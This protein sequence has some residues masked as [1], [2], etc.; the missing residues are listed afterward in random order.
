M[1][2]LWGRHFQPCRRTTKLQMA[3]QGKANSGCHEK[4]PLPLSQPNAPHHSFVPHDGWKCRPPATATQVATIQTYRPRSV[5]SLLM[6]FKA[7]A[8]VLWYVRVLMWCRVRL[9]VGE[10]V[11]ALGSR[12]GSRCIYIVSPNGRENEVDGGE[13]VAKPKTGRRVRRQTGRQANEQQEGKKKWKKDS[14]AT[15]RG[16]SRWVPSVRCVCVCAHV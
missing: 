15:T 11:F 9:G 8:T 16:E 5:S 10:F 7:I 12:L 14:T 4:K 3:G 6:R 1:G 2:W 13:K